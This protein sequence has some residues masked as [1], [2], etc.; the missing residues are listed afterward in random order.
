[1]CVVDQAREEAESRNLTLEKE[2]S[3]YL[4]HGW[5]HLVGFDDQNDTDRKNMRIEEANALAI[6]EK[7]LLWPNFLLAP[8]SFEV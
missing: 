6:V 8:Q 4:I 2:L 1:M 5:L 3:L 7:D